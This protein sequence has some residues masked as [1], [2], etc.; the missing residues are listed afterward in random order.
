MVSAIMTCPFPVELCTLC[1]CINK[2][3]VHCVSSLVLIGVIFAASSL[4]LSLFLHIPSLPGKR[5]WS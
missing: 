5:D 4:V 3:W 1:A 2:D